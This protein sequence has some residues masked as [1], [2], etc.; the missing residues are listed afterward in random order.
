M[1]PPP[2]QEQQQQQQHGCHRHTPDSWSPQPPPAGPCCPTREKPAITKALVPLDGVVMQ[3]F[4]DL[5]GHWALH[6]C[7]RNPGPIQVGWRGL[8][9]YG[10]AGKGG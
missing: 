8:C 7:Y 6:D 9:G 4:R 5:R 2:Q 3:T 1:L 10:R